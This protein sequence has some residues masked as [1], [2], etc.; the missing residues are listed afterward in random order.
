MDRISRS[1]LAVVL[2]VL[3][4]VAP[5]ADRWLAGHAE[6]KASEYLSEP[7]GHPATVR[8]HGTPFLTQALRGRYSDV[9]VTG[10]LRVGEIAAATPNAHR[11]TSTCRCASCSADGPPSCRASTSTGRIVLPYGELARV[12]RIPGLRAAPVDDQ[13]IA[14]AALPVPGIS[15][16]ARVSGEAVLSTGSGGS[17]W[18]RI[19][20]RLR[21]GHQPAAASCST[22]CC[23]RSTSRSRSR[24]CPTGCGCDELRPTADGPR[25]VR[26]GRGRR[27]RRLTG[28]TF[29][30]K[31][32]LAGWRG[33]RAAARLTA[34]STAIRTAPSAR[35]SCAC[36]SP[37]AARST[38]AA[39]AAACVARCLIG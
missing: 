8:V 18:L 3:A 5:L 29:V 23:R 26:L 35:A 14:S 32:D 20:R 1:I 38:C 15:Q 34:M 21:R 33:P 22:S 4:I 9:E 31:C 27:L 16:L 10:G 13:L 36:C 6:R 2:V 28:E 17:V 39:W 37:P 11:A 25:G 12:A 30:P 19:T 7:F 24:S